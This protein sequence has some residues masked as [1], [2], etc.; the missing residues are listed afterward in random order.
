MLKGCVGSL[1]DGC[2]VIVG[3][4]D[5]WLWMFS[6]VVVVVRLKELVLVDGG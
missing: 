3:L 5:W 2:D 6:V 4:V 1:V